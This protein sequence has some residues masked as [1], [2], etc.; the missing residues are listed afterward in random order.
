M[1]AQ[2]ISVNQ[3]LLHNLRYAKC[4]LLKGIKIALVLPMFQLIQQPLSRIIYS[5]KVLILALKLVSTG[6]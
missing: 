1:L 3:N 2:W 5:K 6:I 4:K